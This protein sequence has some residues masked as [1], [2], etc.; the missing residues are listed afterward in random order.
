MPGPTIPA[1]A[2]QVLVAWRHTTGAGPYVATYGVNTGAGSV[3][4]CNQLMAIWVARWQVGV[5][6]V[7]RLTDVQMWQGPS[8]G[9]SIF[10]S[11][12][13]ASTGTSANTPAPPNCT[14]VVRKSTAAGG[15]RGK[16]RM[17]LP[18]VIEANVD[19]LGQVDAGAM[20][21]YNGR[22]A[23]LLADHAAAGMAM[24]LLH[25]H[26]SSIPTPITGLVVAPKIG[27]LRKR[28]A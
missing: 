7:L 19:S 21:T 2:C 25:S 18:G 27:T 5:P 10:Q 8:G 14:W 9:L 3:A 17:H 13:A 28:L 12:S 16:G 20:T 15:R 1:G 24:T 26:G 23:L 11:S 22:L 6:N 4:K